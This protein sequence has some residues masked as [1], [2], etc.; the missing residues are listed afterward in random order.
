MNDLEL[1]AQQNRAIRGYIMRSLVKGH[2]STLLCR[3]LVNALTRAGL[4]VSPDISEYL[5]Y[6]HD[7]GYIEYLDQRI[8]SYNIYANDGVIKLSVR[9]RDLIEG[10]IPEDPGVDI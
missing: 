10:N 3:Q 2:R 4:V 9:G 1:Q 8:D 7:K 6:L 5:E